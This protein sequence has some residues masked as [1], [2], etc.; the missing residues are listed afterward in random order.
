MR[1]T[2]DKKPVVLQAKTK[3]EL[4]DVIKRQFNCSWCSH[5]FRPRIGHGYFTADVPTRRFNTGDK[6]HFVGVVFHKWNRKTK[7]IKRAKGAISPKRRVIREAHW[8]ANVYQFPVESLKSFAQGT[9]TFK[10]E[11]N[12]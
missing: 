10:L 4:E 5:S 11:F 8:T 3:R 1:F 6:G 2:I 12:V 9:R 7:E